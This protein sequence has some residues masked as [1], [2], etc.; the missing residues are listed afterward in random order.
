M[1]TINIPLLYRRLKRHSQIILFV[2]RF[3]GLDN[4]LGSCRARSVY[5]TTL[6]TG[7]TLSSK[8]LTSIVQILSPGTDNCPS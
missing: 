8:R 5:L 2:L 3:S 6:F 7:Q 4:P 1:S